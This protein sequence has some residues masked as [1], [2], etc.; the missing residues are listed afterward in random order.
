[1]DSEV[2]TMSSSGTG[3]GIADGLRQEDKHTH[4]IDPKYPLLMER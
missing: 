1:M 3:P 4:K 2:G